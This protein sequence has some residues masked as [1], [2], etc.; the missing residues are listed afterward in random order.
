VEILR[1]RLGNIHEIA[2]EYG[3]LSERIMLPVKN[4][5]L[6]CRPPVTCN[7]CWFGAVNLEYEL[8]LK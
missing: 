2:I 1:S 4:N 6:K 8:S 7:K 5:F 3:A